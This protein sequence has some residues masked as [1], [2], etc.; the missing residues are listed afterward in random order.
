MR[1]GR[2]LLWGRALI[3][4]GLGLPLFWLLRP[5]AATVVHNNVGSVL[6][7]RALLAPDLGPQ[8]RTARAVEAGQS[9]QTALAWDPLNGQAYYNLAA[10]YDLWQDA[11]SAGRAL[12]RAAVL[13][14]SDISARF[15]HG[16][17][18]AAHEQEARAIHEWQAADAA[19][20]FLN[21]GSV[22]ASEGDP[23][24][25]LEQY[26]RAL[27]VAPDLP[28]THYHLGQALS[29]LGREKEAL[30][31]FEWAAAL[32]PPSSPRRH[33]LQGEVHATRGEWA[34]A[35]AAYGQA[36]EVAPH[37]PAPHY[38]MGWL[39]QHRL[40]DSDG[41][42]ARFEWAIRLDP[43]YVS[44][45][46]ALAQLYAEQ[47]RCDEVG[48]SL[49]PLLVPDAGNRL[50]GQAHALVGRC[51][52]DQGRGDEG[53]WHLEQ[54]ADLNPSSAHYL[55]ILAQGYSHEFHYHEAIEAHLRVLELQPGNSQAKEAL[56]E[57]GW[58]GTTEDG[59]Q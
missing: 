9:F 32:E 44:A 17:A 11:P 31:A 54:A 29:R 30:A 1:E 2:T 46:L 37:D 58:F 24:G 52:L 50:A 51:L 8:Q 22:L 7:N 5:L 10:V 20:Y 26:E 23:T 16:Q 43:E 25:A 14:P 13:D 57:L 40:D 12:S 38:R 34:A 33:L 42:I 19:V 3:L 45:R 48:R 53:L 6:L 59:Q 56:E 39:L 15:R 28:E 27:A 47:A 49:A 35:L 21:Q 36:A 41:A 4:A 18:L 55:L